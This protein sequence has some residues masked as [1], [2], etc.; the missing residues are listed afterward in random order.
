M[1]YIT[2]AVTSTLLD[3]S[4]LQVTLPYNREC[5]TQPIEDEDV[6]EEKANCHL[7]KI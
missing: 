5:A 7:N 6:I 1:N 4:K 3:V 2:T